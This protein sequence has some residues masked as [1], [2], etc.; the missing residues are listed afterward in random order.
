MTDRNADIAAFVRTVPDY[1]RPGVLF[2]DLT[3]LIAE[4]RAFRLTIDRLAEMLGDVPF[5]RIAAVEARGFIFAAALAY[6]MGVGT[7]ILRKPGKLPPIV[8]AIDYALEY[9]TDRL[10]MRADA[11]AAGDRVVL[12]DDLIATGGTALAA[13]SLLRRLGAEVAAAAFVIDLPALGGS[14]AL[15]EA[16]VGV[17]SLLTA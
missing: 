15:T 11:C 7:V 3:P 10:E 4:G 14:A 8:H 16:G 13:V 1:P 2:R 5:D 6:R 12:I 17:R 9:G